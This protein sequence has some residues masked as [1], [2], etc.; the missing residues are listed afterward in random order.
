ATNMLI[1]RLGGLDALTQRF[2]AWGLT[3]TALRNQ[4]PDLSGTNTTSA[5]DLAD[6][7][8]QINQGRLVSPQ[9]RDRIFSIMERTRN[10]TLLPQGIGSE[11]DIAHKTGDIGTLVGDAGVVDMPNGKRY[12]IAVLVKRPYNDGR[13]NELISRISQTVYDHLNRPWEISTSATKSPAQPKGN[14]RSS[15]SA[16]P[17]PANAR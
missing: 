4:L 1:D 15:S 17:S 2:K 12:V 8:L 11:A 6:L 7:L 5:R 3:S 13:A 16:S 10:N 9:S 14:D